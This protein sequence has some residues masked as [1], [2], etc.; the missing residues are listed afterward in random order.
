MF[1][2]LNYSEVSSE[3]LKKRKVLKLIDYSCDL[4]YNSMEK[5]FINFSVVNMQRGYELT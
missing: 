4:C 5:I 2:E 3:Q 1:G